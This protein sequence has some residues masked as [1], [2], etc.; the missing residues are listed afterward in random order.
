MRIY[1]T[2]ISG[3]KIEIHNKANNITQENIPLYDINGDGNITASDY[4][5]VKNTFLGKSSLSGAF[6]EA[7]DANKNGSITASDYARIKNNFLG[8]SSISQ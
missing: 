4:A 6:K 8:K 3:A 2:S 1:K 7:A 5:R